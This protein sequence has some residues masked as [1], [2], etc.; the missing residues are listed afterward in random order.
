MPKKQDNKLTFRFPDLPGEERLKEL[1]LF[2]SSEC[3]KDPTFGA[4]KLNKILFFSDFLFYRATGKPITGVEY[5]RLEFGPAPKPLVKVRE[6]MIKNRDLVVLPSDYFQK[7]QQRTIPSRE[8]ELKKYF[9]PVEIA[10]VLTII[11]SLWGKTAREVSDMSH[12]LAWRIVA[13][14]ES[15]PYEACF[16]SEDAINE[17]DIE[18]AREL[19]QRYHWEPIESPIVETAC[20]PELQPA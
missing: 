12:Q 7:K 16:L 3:A 17:T 15:I 5:F 8:P 11:R 19:N 14:R 6:E 1:I 20:E 18:E 2:I 9:K 10:F 13:D 4:T